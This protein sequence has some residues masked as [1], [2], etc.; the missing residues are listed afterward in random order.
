MEYMAYIAA[1]NLLLTVICLVLITQMGKARKE[2]EENLTASTLKTQV[3]PTAPM[4][5][6]GEDDGEI[7]AAIMAAVYAYG[8]SDG[9]SY[10]IKS[11][12]EKKTQKKISA[13]RH[14]AWAEAGRISN[15][16]GF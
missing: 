3:K 15:T 11:I 9:T 7:V 13:Q 8:I 5:V 12:T 10:E 1:L 2:Y 6:Q 16:S 4:P 14:N